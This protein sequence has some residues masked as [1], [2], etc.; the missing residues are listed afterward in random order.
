MIEFKTHDATT[1]PDGAKAILE[2][3]KAST[4]M[5]PNLYG[6]LAESPQILTAYLELTKLFSQSSLSTVERH[7]VWLAINVENRCHYCVPAHTFLALKDNVPQD[8]ID[9]LR[10][11]APIA[12]PRLEALRRF[13]K[14]V[15]LTRG[16]AAQNEIDAFLAAGYTNANVLD[17]VLGAAHKTISNYVNHLSETPVD[18]PFAKYAWTAPD[19]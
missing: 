12:D 18:A 17:V 7:V 1:A 13:A 2:N 6:V 15:V 14:Q 19:A 11:D 3:A 16:F 9:S 10:A 5:V 4:G 8:V